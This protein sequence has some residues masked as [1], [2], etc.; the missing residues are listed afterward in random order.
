MEANEFYMRRCLDLA[1][2]GLGR[3][4][5]NP[6]VGSVIVADSKIIGEGYH[7]KFGREHAEVCAINNVVDKELFKEAT[8]YVNL[9]PCAHHG[10]TPPCADLIVSKGISRVVIGTADPFAEVNGKGIK[11]LQ[12]AGV[13]VT[14]NVLEQ[15][16]YHLN[17]RFFTFHK[18]KRP[19][20]ILKWAQT[21]DKFIAREDFSSKWISNEFSRLLSHKWRAEEDAIMVGANTALYDDPML[22]SRDMSYRNPVRILIDKSGRIPADKKLFDGSQRTIVFTAAEGAEVQNVEFIKTDFEQPQV[23]KRI[24]KSLYELGIQSLIV[25]GGAFLINNFI[26]EGQWDEARVFTAAVNFNTGIS[27]PVLH[28]P[29]ALEENV[30]G[31]RLEVYLRES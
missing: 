8:L 31:D 18:E 17:R 6:M 10:K 24:F 5:T 3:V 14:V 4:S 23:L 7:R 15:E 1:A 12:E 20:V 19:Y 9:E 25:E 13:E 26:K 27:A 21:A 28:N 29:P 2:K 11:K 30:D 22:N 16:C